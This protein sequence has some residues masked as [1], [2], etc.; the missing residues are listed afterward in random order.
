MKQIKSIDVLND[1]QIMRKLSIAS[2]LL[3]VVF[4]ALFGLLTFITASGSIIFGQGFT[5]SSLLLLLGI[6]VAHELIH[7][8]FF[9]VFN[10]KGKVKFGFKN[11]MAYAT[12]PHSFY[13]KI[14]FAIIVLAPF[15]IL[16]SVLLF[17]YLKGFL[18]PVSFMLMSAFHASSC[19][20]DFYFAYLL[21]TMPK[22][23]LV[24]DTPVGIN[25]YTKEIQDGK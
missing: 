8:F 25:F 6:I 15:I 18:S 11:G 1:K 23:V 19:A 7:G 2:L 12:S 22:S 24:E 10:P 21:S 9:K 3:F 17:A 20:G 5:F 16:N 4:F 13:P 14:P